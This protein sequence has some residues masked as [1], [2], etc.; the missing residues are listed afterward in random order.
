MSAARPSPAEMRSLLREVHATDLAA[1]VPSPVSQ[2]VPSTAT[3]TP[4]S[5]TGAAGNP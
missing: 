3:P 4:R 2:P 1:S 5:G